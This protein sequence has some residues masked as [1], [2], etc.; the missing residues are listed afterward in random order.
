MDL[1]ILDINVDVDKLRSS[2]KSIQRK[3]PF[4]YEP[5]RE[6]Y[7]GWSIQSEVENGSYDDG[8]TVGTSMKMRNIQQSVKRTNTNIHEYNKKTDCCIEYF[9]E[10]LNKFDQL[11][12]MTSRARVAYM[13]P[14]RELSLHRD[15]P[16]NIY[17]C[18][19]H[20]PIFT[21]YNCWHILYDQDGVKEIDRVHLQVGNAY[22]FKVNNFH[23]AVNWGEQDRY[24]FVM[25][26]FDSHQITRLNKFDPNVNLV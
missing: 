5:F 13:G 15:V 10:L 12:F 18:R 16:P 3:Y 22:M 21:N 2:L 23:K 14:D 8:W 26:G 4:P 25:N 1:E 6:G 11:G 20:I 24:H 19:I 17:R 7:G 9:D